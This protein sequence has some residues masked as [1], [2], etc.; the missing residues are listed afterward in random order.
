MLFA[1][2]MI[3][4]Y[5]EPEPGR[6]AIIVLG[7]GLDGYEAGTTLRLRLDRA[8]E[9]YGA[10][11]SAVIVASGGQGPDQLIPE[12]QAMR[13]YLVRQGVPESAVIM[14]KQSRDTMQNLSFSKILLD[15]HFDGE[16][17]VVVATSDFHIFRSLNI[18][19]LIGFNDPQ[20]AASR[21]ALRLLPGFYAREY[22]ALMYYYLLESWR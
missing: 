19:R 5:G 21:S 15:G 7:C 10:N 1:A 18:A 4:K 9:Y 12:A 14:E 2:N 13:N 6:D 3:A 16:Y 8:L 11:P 22:A 20:P 17:N